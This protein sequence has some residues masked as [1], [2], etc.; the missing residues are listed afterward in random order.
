MRS[1][2][3]VSVHRG[4][5]EHHQ[6]SYVTPRPCSMKISF[7]KICYKTVKSI[8]EKKIQ[9]QISIAKSGNIYPTI[10]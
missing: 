2:Y 5:E 10:Y 7:M 9:L 1:W 8:K 3:F 6:A 4:V